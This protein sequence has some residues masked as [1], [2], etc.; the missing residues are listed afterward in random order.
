[1]EAVSKF[2]NHDVVS[3]FG[4]G[5]IKKTPIRKRKATNDEPLTPEMQIEMKKLF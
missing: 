3:L 1:L 4:Q 5:P 2:L